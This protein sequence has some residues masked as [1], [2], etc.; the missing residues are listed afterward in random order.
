MIKFLNLR[1]QLKSNVFSALCAYGNDT[2]CK[3]RVVEYVC[4]AYGIKDDGFSIDRLENPN[5][6]D[7][8]L[9]CLTPSMFCD[10]RQLDEQ[11]RCL[12]HAKEFP[13]LVRR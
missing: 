4:D 3:K 8:A 12:L 2:W 7:V 13:L 6:E 1:E 9:A 5:A 11:N 10:K